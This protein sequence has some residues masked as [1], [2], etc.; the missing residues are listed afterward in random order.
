LLLTA[1]LK[2]VAIEA[3]TISMDAFEFFS[4]V[5]MSFCF[6]EYFFN[7]KKIK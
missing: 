2:V 5:S 4:F 1:N 6:K 3:L 7:L